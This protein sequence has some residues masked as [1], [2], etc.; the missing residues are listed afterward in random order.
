MNFSEKLQKLVA[1]IDGAA[2]ATADEAEQF[3]IKYLGSKGVFKELFEEFKTLS[4]EEKR[5][6][7]KQLN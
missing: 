2:A 6:F 7:G 5:T 4:S 3:R 1:E